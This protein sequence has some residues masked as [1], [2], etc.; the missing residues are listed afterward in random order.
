MDQSEIAAAAQEFEAARARGEY[1]PSAW[2]DRL[3]LDDAYRI[4]L[5]L[6]GRRRG[7]GERRIGWKIGLTAPVIQR[8]FGLHQPVFACLLAGGLARSG[9]VFRRDAL[10]EPGFENELCIV[11]DRTARC[12]GRGRAR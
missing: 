9:H 2:F 1:F 12:S 10:I 8:Q 7:D 6:I 5:A 3:T 4:L 11:L